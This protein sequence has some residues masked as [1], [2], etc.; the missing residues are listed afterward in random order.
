MKQ[1]V[2]ALLYSAFL[3][4]LEVIYRQ[5]F[6]ISSVERYLESYL[7]TFLF[8]CLFFYSKYRIT[9]VLIAILF[10]ISILANNMH[11]ALYQSW[12]GPVNYSLVFKE[13]TEVTN[14]GITMVNKF[15]YPLLFGVFEVIVF[16]SL[17][18]IKRKT[19]KYSWFFDFVFYA[20]MMYV[21]VRA[22][23]TKS[24]ERFISPN[25]TYS[26]LKSNYFS[27]GYFIGRILPYEIFSLSDI[28]LYHKDKPQKS[29]SPKIKNIILIMGESAAASHF[30]AFDYKRQTSPFLVSFKEKEGVVL[31]KAYSGGLLTAISLPMFFN[32]I[33]YPNG[34]Q[35]IAKGETNLFNLAKLQNF[36]TYFYSAQARDDM[37]MINFLGGAWI[38]QVRF[39]DNEGY[40][41]RDSMPD[42]NLLPL[43]KQINLDEGAHFIVLHHRG[44]H[45]PYGE[46][47]DEKDKVFGKESAI[48][49]YDN[50]ILNTD[51][52][53]SNVYQYL[54]ERNVDDWVIAYTSDHG[55]YVK[56]D[57]YRQG[58]RDK[59]S[60]VVPLV[61]YS[62]NKEIQSIGLNIFHSCKTVFHYQLSSFL[63]NIMGY[64]F[65]IGDCKSGIVNGNILTGDAGYLKIDADGK[66]EYVH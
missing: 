19:Y 56:N 14:A 29:G 50:T 51:K 48:D 20:V 61:L 32:A 41:L 18:F 54:S 55:Q 37:H 38:D 36:K 53:I 24:H 49:N 42:N 31:T 65:Q 26:R 21:F 46:L 33:P 66:E 15:I 23:T 39:P 47:L 11:Y 16:L 2:I 59:D 30:S 5:L 9:R 3:L 12:I 44:S 52:F 25:T 34:V 60:Y 4:L 62:P 45:I 1:L 43:F 58:T 40:S 17:S 6:N 28:P 22:Y 63:I 7:W 35:Q 10:T 27:L 57:T 8:V 64:N 13:I